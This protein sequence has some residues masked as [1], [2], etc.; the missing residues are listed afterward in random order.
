MR[1]LRLFARADRAH[2][3]GDKL[4]EISGRFENLAS[5]VCTTGGRAGGRQTREKDEDLRSWC[6]SFMRDALVRA[7]CARNVRNRTEIRQ[8]EEEEGE[9]GEEEGE[10]ERVTADVCDRVCKIFEVSAKFLRMR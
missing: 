6:I 2:R 1:Q 7:R 9:G 5:E 8:E 10:S 3:G 4:E